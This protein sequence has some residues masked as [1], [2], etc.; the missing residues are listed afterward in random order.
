V[1]DDPFASFDR[2]RLDNALSLLKVIARENQVLLMTHDPYIL[3]WAREV[4]SAGD[5]P[6]AIRELTGPEHQTL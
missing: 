5:V 1:L 4:S 2:Q 6:C 3:D